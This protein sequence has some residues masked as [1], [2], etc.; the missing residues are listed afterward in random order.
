MTQAFQ[1][2]MNVWMKW[3]MKWRLKVQES[4]GGNLSFSLQLMTAELLKA[5]QDIF[6][7][8]SYFR[9]SH[10]VCIKFIKQRCF[11]EVKPLFWCA[12]TSTTVAIKGSCELFCSNVICCHSLIGNLNIVKFM[13]TLKAVEPHLT[14]S[15]IHLLV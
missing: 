6:N 7:L 12:T 5:F 9:T 4:L 3:N 2:R 11:I 14:C 10:E 15:K 13:A 8:P 1:V